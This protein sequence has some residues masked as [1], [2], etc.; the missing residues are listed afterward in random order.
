M[1]KH[2]WELNIDSPEEEII[3]SSKAIINDVGTTS[4][5]R[6]FGLQYNLQLL[7]LKQQKK[8]LD[9]QKTNNEENNTS[10]RTSLKLTKWL[11]LGTLGSL[12]IGLIMNYLQVYSLNQQISLLKEQVNSAE[13][14]AR[15]F[16]RTIVDMAV[17]EKK[18]IYLNYSN[19]GSIPAKLIYYNMKAVSDD[20]SLN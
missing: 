4:E 8:L 11:V 17:K 12:I 15:P 14:E 9:D 7:S 6:N 13:A 3:E 19:E 20:V 18:I 5:T 2:S 10:T 16:L 1:S